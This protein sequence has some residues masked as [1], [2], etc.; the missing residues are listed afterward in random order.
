[1][2]AQQGAT[3]LTMNAIDRVLNAGHRP[4]A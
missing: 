1:V 3:E 4:P 2:Q